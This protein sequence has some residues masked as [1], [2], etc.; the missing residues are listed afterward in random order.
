MGIQAVPKPIFL[1]GPTGV[2]KSEVALLLAEQL[3]GEI[4]SV[5]SMQVYRGLNI[6]TAKL[7][8]ADR[9]GV[10]HHLLD[11]VEPDQPFDAHQF[12]A[13]P[14]GRRRNQ[15]PRKSPRALW[16]HRPLL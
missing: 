1:A 2:G 15:Q 11:V 13:G 3:D 16:G 9:H 14:F 7:A 12:V 10:P 8:P 5:D 4:V 6:G